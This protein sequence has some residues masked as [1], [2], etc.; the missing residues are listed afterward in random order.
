[1]KNG[2]AVENGGGTVQKA[3]KK[4]QALAVWNRY[5]KSYTAMI[6]LVLLVLLTLGAIFADQ[7]APYGYDDQNY[8]A[9]LEG[10]SAEHLMGTDN[11]GR[12]IFSRVL[13]GARI[14]LTVG[15]LS[16]TMS[17]VIG[18]VMGALAAYY[19][20]VVDNALMRFIDILMA[21]PP[22]VLSIS[23]CAALGTGVFNTMIALSISSIPQFARVVRAGVL[24]VKG[25]EYIEA[26]R[27]VGG[28]TPRLILRHIIPNT[29]GP[30][31]VQATLSI[32]GSILNMS[33]LSFIG[34]GVQPPTPEWGSM[35]SAGR[36]YID[37]DPHMVIFPG[38]A[39][40]LAVF[41]LNLVGDGLRDALDPRLKR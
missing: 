31:I 23:V 18:G 28:K 29:M 4:S 38:I 33:G 26:A 37:S 40:M 22:L 25:Q 12:D 32:A 39:I 17:V 19:G 7:I 27:S 16:V 35:L 8:S 5:R 36:A 41:S 14:S 10:V 34:L 21:V 30:L 11:V 1:M 24:T 20:G 9:I 2:I 6:G 3:K 13:H 15:L